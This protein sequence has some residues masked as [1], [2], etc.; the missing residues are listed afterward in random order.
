MRLRVLLT[1]TSFQDIPG[2]HQTLLENQNLEIVK[3]RG[4]LKEN[5]L[6]EIIDGFDG[7][8]C[9]DDE[10]TKKVIIKGISGR[11]KII[12][13][14]GIGLDKIDL[15]AAAEN[16]LPVKSCPGVNQV[17]VAE[18]VF[19][20]LLSFIKNIIPENNLIKQQN[21]ERLIG[22]EL[23]EKKIGIVGLGNVGKEVAKRAD[24]FGMEVYAFDKYFDFEF[25]KKYNVI[26]VTK[27]EDLLESSDIVSLN[28][29]LNSSTFNLI[30]SENLIKLKKGVIIVN[31]ARAGLVEQS[32]IIEGLKRKIISGYLTDVL[33]EEPMIKDHPLL[34]YENVIITP[35]IGS[36]TYENVVKQGK[37]AVDNLLSYFKE[38]L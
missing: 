31:T 9:G 12:S 25:A 11:L 7:L 32:A 8:L 10:I 37:M 18:H 1:S 16:K 15:I 22:T 23:Y 36:R 30:N 33:D 19:A 38:N 20:L 6:L 17:T 14:Y 27:L 28:A 34:T 2:E 13:K 3:L 35:H 24:A 5:I 29:S 4:P 21:W 26:E